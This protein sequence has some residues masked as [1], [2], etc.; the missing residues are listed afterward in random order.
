MKIKE[1]N[2]KIYGKANIKICHISDI[3]FSKNYNLN[4]FDKL[5]EYIKTKKVDYICIT[6]DTLDSA[7]IIKEK[8]IKYLIKF[9]KNLSKIAKVIISIGNHDESFYIKRKTEYKDTSNFFNKLKEENIIILNNDYYETKDVIFIGYTK[10]FKLYKNELT[11]EKEI[12]KEVDKLIKDTNKYQIL[13]SHSP[14]GMKNINV[15]LILCG[16]NHNGLVPT[17]LEK[18][19]KHRGIV[20]PS[21][22]F[23][24]KDTRGFYNENN[25]ININGG[26]TKLS[27]VSG[28]F[29]HFNKFFKSHVD[30]IEI[31]YKNANKM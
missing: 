17:K 30:F 23:F 6:G 9:I 3:H 7:N 25:I 15:D 19:F 29:R 20:S 31:S 5:F 10:T 11:K 13:L 16:H 4:V 1:N 22:I 8:E 12:K 18:I 2:Y 27:Y 26:I 24:P 14:V 21:K 28:F